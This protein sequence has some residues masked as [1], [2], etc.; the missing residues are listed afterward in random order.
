MQRESCCT[1]TSAGLRSVKRRENALPKS[2]CIIP[3]WS[4]TLALGARGKRDV[5]VDRLLHQVLG[6][7]KAVVVNNNAAAVFLILNTLAENGE[8]L[9]SR[10]E[11]IE[12][13][14]SFRIPDILRK[15]GAVLRE[16]G[17]HQQ[18]KGLGLP[19]GDY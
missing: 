1:P 6:C 10:G 18:N 4:L 19:G 12:I 9:I 16:V 17:H 14:D 8:V 5:F 11:L 2:A 3:T 7:Q 15:S 13:G